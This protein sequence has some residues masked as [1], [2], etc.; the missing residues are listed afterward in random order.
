MMFLGISVKRNVSLNSIHSGSTTINSIMPNDDVE[1]QNNDLGKKRKTLKSASTRE[2]DDK[3]RRA[4]D[5]G[6]VVNDTSLQ[7]KWRLMI[8][9]L[10]ENKLS[11]V[12]ESEEEIRANLGVAGLAAWTGVLPKFNNVSNMVLYHQHGKAATIDPIGNCEV[13]KQVCT[14]HNCCWFRVHQ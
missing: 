12:E 7:T 14:L 3:K 10:E 5:Q 4:V 9:G 8:N 13:V 11:D 6:V 2:S 1:D